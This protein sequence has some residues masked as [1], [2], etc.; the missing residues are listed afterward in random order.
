MLHLLAELKGVASF[1]HAVVRQDI[2]QGVAEKA[3]PGFAAKGLYQ[4]TRGLHREWRRG[5]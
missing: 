1:E 3:S 4:W 2:L 5:R